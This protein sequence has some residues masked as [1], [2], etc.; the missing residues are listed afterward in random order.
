MFLATLEK[1][2]GHSHFKTIKY[3]KEITDKKRGKIFSK[4]SRVISIAA[5]EKGGDPAMNPSLK[6]AIEKAKEANMPKDNIEKAIKRGTGELAG[7]KLEEVLFDAYGPEGVAIIIEGIT[8]NTNRTLGEIKQALNQHGGKLASEGSVRWMFEKKG[9]IAIDAKSQ[10][11]TSKK[12]GLELLAI[13]AGADDALWRDDY[14]YVYTK[15][16]ELEKVKTSLEE[17]GITIEDSSLDWIAKEKAETKPESKEAC[18][19]LFEALDE[20]DAVQEIYS[21]IGD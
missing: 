14:L 16:E 2:S 18:L 10:T 4:L 17:K 11:S 15:P 6:L 5:K 21:N 9:Y 20:L 12:E 1:M 19:K 13:E 7:E 3:R 8:D